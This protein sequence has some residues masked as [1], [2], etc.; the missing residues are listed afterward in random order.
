M[1]S[2]DILTIVFIFVLINIVST[3]VISFVWMYYR[4]RYKGI[5]FLA[6]AFLMQMVAY[7][8]IILRNEIP[9]WISIDIGNSISIAGL[10]LGYIGFEH[11]TGKKS[12]QLYNL[13]LLIIFSAFHIWFTY[14]K[15]DM[16]I[17][18]LLISV[19]SLTFFL[20][21]AYLL[22]F[23][24]PRNM[25]ILTRKTGIVFLGFCLICI[26]KI[27]EYFAGGIKPEDY[28]Q[29]GQFEGII[30]ISYQVLIIILI[31]SIVLMLN[32]HLLRDISTEEEKFSTT[33]NTAPN[34]IVLTSF[35]EG[36]IIEANTVFFDLTGH[37]A[38]EVTGKTITEI[39]IWNN[40]QDRVNV[41]SE[42]TKSG[43]VSKRELK[44]R[45]KSGDIINCQLSS[46]IISVGNEK[47]LIT[48][49]YDI[50]ERK[51]Y[52]EVIR[53]ERNL[54][55]TL[56]DHLP[57]PV[58][59]KDADG[60]YLLN[61]H[62]HLKV[63][64]AESQVVAIG[65]TVF[66]FF[67]EKNA[68][69][70]HT[71]DKSVI[72]TGKM[73]LDKV[74]MVENMETG[75]PQW[76][77]TSKIP[78]CDE[79]GKTV[80]VLTISHDITERKR[81]EDALKESAEFNRSLL[82]TIPFGMD[83]VDE[84]GTILFHSDNFKKVFGS[85]TIG[86]KCWEIYRDDKQQCEDC[87]LI[88]GINIGATEI[89][90]S[91]N[92][93]GGK[94]FEINHTGMMFRGKKAMLEIFNDIT[95]RKHAEE[96]LIES[97]EKAEESDRLK[98][99]FLHNISH[100]IRT[101]MNAIVG[102]ANL[103][104]DPNLTQDDQFSYTDIISKSSQHLLS[105]VNDVVEMANVEAGKLKMSMNDFHLNSLLNDLYQQFK[106]KADLQNIEI[107]FKAPDSVHFSHFQTDSTKL[108]Q[109][110][111]NLINNAFKFTTEGRIMF[112]YEMVD[113]FLEFY[114]SDSGIGI[115]SNQHSK[116]FERFYQIDSTESRFH[117]GTGLGLSISKA[118]VELLG[119]KIWLKSEMGKGSVF[120]FTIPAS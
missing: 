119:G 7:I 118:Y 46:K 79:N 33:F 60:R 19:A 90:E 5:G 116:I 73:H 51:K 30:M 56:L 109:I 20:Q 21:Y 8:L 92:I 11:Y 94:V 53:H 71:D 101:P 52:Q 47:C 54:L 44:F 31:F 9:L 13:I 62:A 66:D 113:G 117:E 15:P 108:V 120:Y 114:V 75:F 40:P 65:K 24:V 78:I 72:H 32:K 43:Q 6:L 12:S 34:A 112:G 17:R 106:P 104:R 35:P 27:T 48:S 45:T 105:I 83:I 1:I 107:S 99:A 42:L 69:A 59:L 96:N 29:S 64:G 14:I 38:S 102:F 76:Y 18:Y 39:G 57:D 74:E 86:R 85:E 93:L 63:I 41:I 68:Q 88:K 70:Y 77:L 110:L 28:F 95:K 84:S 91:H 82:K 2:L 81:S 10:F 26:I 49:I 55:K 87:P 37:L 97:K 16:T 58:A 23:R 100:E 67:Q 61:N 98:T 80:Q 103:L 89:F 3:L 4:K 22:L 36:K 25:L 111:S 50:T 115:D